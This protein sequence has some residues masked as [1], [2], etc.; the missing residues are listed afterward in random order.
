MKNNFFVSRK[1]AFRIPK[2]RLWCPKKS[3][4]V[5]CITQEDFC[6]PKKAHPNAVHRTSAL[7]SE[8]QKTTAAKSHPSK[9]EAI[10]GCAWPSQRF[11]LAFGHKGELSH[12]STFISKLF[13]Y[14][15]RF[16]VVSTTRTEL[17]KTVRA[18]PL[19]QENSCARP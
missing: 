18:N 11:W 6:T 7:N 12:L 14:N 1:K 17:Q 8:I 4:L 19:F 2:K 16:V 3:T 10:V 15:C 9:N 13:V 5:F